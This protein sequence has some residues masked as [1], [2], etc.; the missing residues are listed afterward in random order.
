MVPLAMLKLENKSDG[1][2]LSLVDMVIDI[3]VGYKRGRVA[4]LMFA[5][6][7]VTLSKKKSTR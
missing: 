5:T 1:F 6:F 7:H 4:L 2:D 3:P